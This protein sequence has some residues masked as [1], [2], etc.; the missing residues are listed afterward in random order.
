MQ[1]HGQFPIERITALF[2]NPLTAQRE[3]FERD[4]ARRRELADNL[5]REAL[6]AIALLADA[7]QRP[8]I[9]TSDLEEAARHVQVAL[10]AA[11]ELDPPGELA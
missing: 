7:A 3:R 1:G 11:R 5:R 4:E 6:E 10:T 8:L 9:A 2:P